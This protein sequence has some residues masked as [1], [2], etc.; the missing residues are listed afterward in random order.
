LLANNSADAP[1]LFQAEEQQFSG[2]TVRVDAVYAALIEPVDVASKLGLVDVAASVERNRIRTEDACDGWVHSEST[3]VKHFFQRR[4]PDSRLAVWRRQSTLEQY[5][6]PTPKCFVPDRLRYV[7]N[8]VND[9][10]MAF[11]AYPCSD[12]KR[13]SWVNRRV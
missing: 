12:D 6:P 1:S 9:Q 4:S 11:A 13:R 5:G 7:S 8:K 3:S 2:R 10:L